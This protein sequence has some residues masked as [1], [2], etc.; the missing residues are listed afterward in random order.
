MYTILFKMPLR[1]KFSNIMY[2]TLD[3]AEKVLPVMGFSK[4]ISNVWTDGETLAV[5][6]KK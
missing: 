2:P 6:I 1:D 3:E 4:N 5:I